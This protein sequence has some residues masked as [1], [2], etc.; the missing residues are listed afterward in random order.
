[1]LQQRTYCRMISLSGNIDVCR[2]WRPLAVWSAHSTEPH[3]QSLW[4]A[5]TTSEAKENRCQVRGVAISLTDSTSHP[6]WWLESAIRAGSQNR[7]DRLNF[8]RRR[9]TSPYGY[10]L[11]NRRAVRLTNVTPGDRRNASVTQLNSVLSRPEALTPMLSI[12][13]GESPL[14]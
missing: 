11:I 7:V 4:C 3:A 10:L 9:T 5:M 6:R 14:P 1:M 8:I 12:L 13:H 2:K